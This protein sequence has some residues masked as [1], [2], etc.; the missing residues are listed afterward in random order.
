MSRRGRFW[1]RMLAALL[2]FFFLLATETILRL[3]GVGY[4]T[5]FFLKQKAEGKTVLADNPKFGWRFFPLEAARTPHP[6]S[7]L[8]EKPPGGVRIFVLGE[9][10]AMGDPEPSYGFGR[11]L[12]R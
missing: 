8:A 12:E 1:F 10:A 5:A 2:P 9:S 3:A 7:I 4:P 6:L 11:Q